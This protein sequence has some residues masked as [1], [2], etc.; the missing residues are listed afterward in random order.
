[1][2][3][4]LNA[5]VLKTGKAKVFVGSNPTPSTS[6]TSVFPKRSAGAEVSGSPGGWQAGRTVKGRQVLAVDDALLDDLHGCDGCPGP[7][8]VALF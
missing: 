3:E 1:M 6:S 7:E 5:P 8:V 2:A 4:R